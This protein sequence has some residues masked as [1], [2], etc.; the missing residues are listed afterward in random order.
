MSK[1]WWDDMGEDRAHC[2]KCDEWSY[3]GAS[4]W[5]KTPAL[6]PVCSRWRAWSLLQPYATLM[7]CDPE[8]C[9]RKIRENRSRLMFRPPPGGMWV[10]VHASLGW[11]SVKMDQDTA[12]EWLS[13]MERVFPGWRALPE[14]AAWP[15]GALLGAVHVV[16]VKVF[17][18]EEAAARRY[19]PQAFGPVVYEI[20]AARSLPAPI[21]CKGAMG[22]W[23]VP[24]EHH[25]AL[26]S[27]LGAP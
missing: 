26:D 9:D 14:A 16:D 25:A 5:A 23:S 12:Y 4:P 8:V 18:S 22:L 24:R 20:D 11:Y 6:C 3:V 13:G 1:I 7:V 15:K 27:L 2:P 17:E 21:P 10:A 19:G